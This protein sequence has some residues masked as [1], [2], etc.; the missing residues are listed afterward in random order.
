MFTKN[1]NIRI[2]RKID[3]KIHCYPWCI[4]CG[5]KKFETINGEELN[6]LLK[7]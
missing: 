3:G 1:T 2:K 6:G 5:F 7:V 4:D